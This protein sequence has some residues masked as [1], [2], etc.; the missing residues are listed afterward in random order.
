M[1]NS[2]SPK[3]KP[4]KKADKKAVVKRR[5]TTFIGGQP[6]K[7]IIEVVLKD[8]RSGGIATANLLGGAGAA[9]AYQI[10]KSEGSTITVLNL[11]IETKSQATPGSSGTITLDF[12]PPTN[13][14]LVSSMATGTGSATLQLVFKD[15]NLFASPVSYNFRG[16][17]GFINELVN[18]Q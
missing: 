16:E 7:I 3:V 9:I 11:T 18:T 4:V 12:I 10:T 14:I 8:E 15:K 5:E 6:I 17:T 1:S 13:K 2:K